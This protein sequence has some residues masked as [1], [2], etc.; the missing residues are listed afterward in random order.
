MFKKHKEK[1]TCIP[2]ANV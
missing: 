1:T 2:S